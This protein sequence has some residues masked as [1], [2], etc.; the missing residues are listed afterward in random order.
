M[1]WIVICICLMDGCHLWN[2]VNLGDE[3]SSS[4]FSNGA[5]TDWFRFSSP[6]HTVLSSPT[7]KWI[8]SF[9][10]GIA[11]V[12][13]HSVSCAKGQ[14]FPS[15]CW[16]RV[17]CGLRSSSNSVAQ[18]RGINKRTKSVG[19]RVSCVWGG[20]ETTVVPLLYH[21]MAVVHFRAGPAPGPCSIVQ[22][23]WWIILLTQTAI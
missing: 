20:R 18:H 6:C 16:P 13:L 1:K 15:S 22:T 5:S 17:H 12:S 10:V 9:P 2:F 14:P 8:N 21:Q 3:L 7:V 19:Q 23:E 11:K 4:T